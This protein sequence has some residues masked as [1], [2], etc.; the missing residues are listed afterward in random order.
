MAFSTSTEKTT[1]S[2]R[3]LASMNGELDDGSMGFK[4]RL[5]A[6]TRRALWLGIRAYG[7]TNAPRV[8]ADFPYPRVT[9]PTRWTG[10]VCI[11]CSICQNWH[12]DD[13]EGGD[14][15]AREIGEKWRMMLYILVVPHPRYYLAFGGDYPGCIFSYFAC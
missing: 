11:H 13:D 6:F 9:R 7:N 3:Q 4:I 10:P 12:R 15:T 2:T 1:S 8:T 5:E 14:G